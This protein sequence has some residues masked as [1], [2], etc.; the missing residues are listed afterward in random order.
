MNIAPLTFSAASTIRIASLTALRSLGDLGLGQTYLTISTIRNSLPGYA[1]IN[2][3]TSD[4]YFIKRLSHSI[5]GNHQNI[6]VFPITQ[7]NQ[8]SCGAMS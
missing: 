8:P 7:P 1:P 3:M 5:N 4:A 2:S 6:H